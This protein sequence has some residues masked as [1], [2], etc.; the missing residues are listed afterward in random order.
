MNLRK[1]LF[2]FAALDSA[3]AA[4]TTFKAKTAGTIYPG[5][6]IAT[7]NGAAPSADAL[8]VS[9]RKIVAVGTKAEVLLVKGPRSR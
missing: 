2:F 5:G 4:I 9:E 1:H 3:G 6:H 8:V 7:N